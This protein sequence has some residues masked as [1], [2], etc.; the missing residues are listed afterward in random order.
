MHKLPKKRRTVS[1]R[2]KR[3]NETP[4]RI[5]D[6]V[7]IHAFVHS[8]KK[9]GT[10]N[11]MVRHHDSDAT[12]QRQSTS[13][14]QK[15]EKLTSE[16]GEHQ[17]TSPRWPFFQSNLKTFSNSSLTYA[18]SKRMA[19]SHSNQSTGDCALTNYQ[20]PLTSWWAPHQYLMPVSPNAT[21]FNADKNQNLSVKPVQQT[22]NNAGASYDKKSIGNKASAKN[23]QTDDTSKST[24]TE[25]ETTM[26]HVASK[27]DQTIADAKLSTST[28]SE[29]QT[30][31]G[32][33][34]KQAT[35]NT[36]PPTLIGK[37]PTINAKSKHAVV[38]PKIPTSTIM[39]TENTDTQSS[40]DFGTI[41]PKLRT[42]T[43]ISKQVSSN[44]KTSTEPKTIL[45]N[46][47]IT[48]PSGIITKVLAT[49]KSPIVGNVIKPIGKNSKK[50]FA[51][52]TV[53]KVLDLKV[54]NSN[55][56]PNV[57]KTRDSE[58]TSNVSTP[59]AH[60]TKSTHVSEFSIEA[61]HTLTTDALSKTDVNDGSAQ[62]RKICNSALDVHPI[63]NGNQTGKITRICTAKNQ[64][65]I[66]NLPR[67]DPLPS[68]EVKTCVS[69]DT[70]EPVDN[71]LEEV[72]QDSSIFLSST[73]EADVNKIKIEDLRCWSANEHSYFLRLISIHRPDFQ[74][75]A[76]SM[77][78][79]DFAQ[80]R[81]Y[82]YYSF[83]GES[84]AHWSVEEYESFLQHLPT[85]WIGTN[86]SKT[87]VID[88]IRKKSELKAN[89]TLTAGKPSV[90]DKKDTIDEK[91]HSES[92]HDSI[93]ASSVNS[94]VTGE[95]YGNAHSNHWR[96]IEIKK[97]DVLQFRGSCKSDQEKLHP[98]NV[99]FQKLTSLRKKE[100]MQHSLKDCDKKRE[101]VTSIIYSIKRLDPPGR[102]LK[103][104][105][106]G[107]CICMSDDEAFIKTRN[108]I[109]TLKSTD[110]FEGRERDDFGQY[111]KN[112]PTEKKGK[113][114][115]TAKNDKTTNKSIRYML[116]LASFNAA[117]PLNQDDDILNQGKR[118]RR[119]RQTVRF[120]EPGDNTA[121]KTDTISKRSR[122]D[123]EGGDDGDNERQYI[124]SISPIRKRKSDGN[125]VEN[126]VP[127]KTMKLRSRTPTKSTLATRPSTSLRSSPPKQRTPTAK[128]KVIRR[129]SRKTSRRVA[130]NA[131]IGFMQRSQTSSPSK[132]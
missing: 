85:H 44:T 25:T 128:R 127:S 72:S 61:S 82:A 14:K 55:Q 59:N 113:K 74:K 116:K 110:G 90:S 17:K 19:L 26:Q 65:E 33:E 83:T 66:D 4:R 42:E 100:Y 34:R 97:N 6:I 95:A 93:N 57:A 43:Q 102:F 80:V 120:F 84:L 124:R 35:A 112:V 108:M 24:S 31:V 69:K 111:K 121:L 88:K 119:Q 98:G 52:R 32:V 50:K 118:P 46:T 8:L 104:N 58:N 77:T 68:I 13:K 37:Q 29:T 103:Y 130:T 91:S 89:G 7:D 27:T 101:I 87:E 96:S 94:T 70:A 49:L 105:T 48:K 15:T 106:R 129:L 64:S 23:D 38:D 56:L 16:K 30:V 76:E 99:H 131:L 18:S 71:N 114:I 117:P 60:N 132:R 86:W 40:T 41:I 11:D 107:R 51:V 45:Q 12:E 81:A 126:T 5:A 22:P 123:G 115:P 54:M 109:H 28:D 47:N 10:T 3:M 73:S 1:A 67:G 53:Y 2:K 20:V 63:K 9:T 62:D 79:R 21:E 75:I 39:E 78:N 125:V 92:E 122:A 36:E